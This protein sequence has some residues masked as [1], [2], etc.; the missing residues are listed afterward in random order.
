METMKEFFKGFVPV[1]NGMGFMQ[2]VLDQYSRSFVRYA[3]WMDDP[4]LEIGAA[5]GIAARAVLKKGAILVANDI[6]AEHLDVLYQS[7]PHD[8]RDRL[9]LSIGSFP[10]DLNF[11]RN[12]FGAILASRVLHFLD[13]PALERGV[14]KLFSWLKPGGKFFMT[15]ISPDCNFFESFRE[16]YEKRKQQQDPWPGYI[17]DI[18]HY[19]PVLWSCFFPFQLHTLDEDIL[20]KLF[21]RHGFQIEKASSFTFPINK[22]MGSSGRDFVGLIALKP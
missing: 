11:P 18:T 1:R 12:S 20:K 6:S 19:I 9:Q 16:T 13:G 8:H 21:L 4:V 10:D 7:I 2:T 5:Y 22:K 3:S 14:K 15:V 17:E